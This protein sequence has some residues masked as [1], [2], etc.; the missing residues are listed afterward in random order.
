MPT[1]ASQLLL[2][3]APAPHTIASCQPNSNS[4]YWKDNFFDPWRSS[5]SREDSYTIR[6][7]RLSKSLEL[8]NPGSFILISRSLTLCFP[9]QA[10]SCSNLIAPPSSSSRT[11]HRSCLRPRYQYKLYIN[12]PEELC[13]QYCQVEISAEHGR[14]E[15]LPDHCILTSPTRGTESGPEMLSNEMSGKDHVFLLAPSH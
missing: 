5:K 13:L 14:V 9:V 1:S 2:A 8:W 7:C 10:K 11:P 3:Q 4:G 12:W 6:V 15:D